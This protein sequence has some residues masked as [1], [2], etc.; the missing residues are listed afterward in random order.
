M[1]ECVFSLHLP[2]GVTSVGSTREEAFARGLLA[3]FNPRSDEFDLR[4]SMTQFDPFL[5]ESTFCVFV[6]V[7]FY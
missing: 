3:G 5:S 2:L 7:V 1:S 6:V 4:G